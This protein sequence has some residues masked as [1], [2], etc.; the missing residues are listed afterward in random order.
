MTTYNELLAKY[1]AAEQDANR[2]RMMRY[3]TTNPESA[4]AQRMNA[5]VEE[6]PDDDP[7]AAEDMRR[8]EACL[9][10]L[11]EEFGAKP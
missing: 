3:I 9:D 8:L 4:E 10:K 5:L 1:D 11:I 2:W 7:D 6:L